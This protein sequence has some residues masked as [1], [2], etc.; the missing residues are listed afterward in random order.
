ML[1]LKTKTEFLVPDGRSTKSVIVRMITSHFSMV[2]INNV[3]VEGYYYYLDEEGNPI[4]LPN[5]DFGQNSMKQWH[6]ITSLE[7]MENSPLANLSSNRNLQTVLLQRLRELT[8]LQ[9]HQES[10]ENYG[11]VADD[12]EEDTE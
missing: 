8:M 12:W 4:K 6:D 7:N 3:K 10:G 2:D 5:S 1:K 11:T 9:L